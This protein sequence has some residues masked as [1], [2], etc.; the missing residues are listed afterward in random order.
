VTCKIHGDTLRFGGVTIF[1]VKSVTI[2]PGL[3]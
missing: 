1:N 3:P 2:I